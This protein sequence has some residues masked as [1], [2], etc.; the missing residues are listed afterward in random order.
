VKHAIAIGFLTAVVLASTARAEVTLPELAQDANYTRVQLD[1]LAIPRITA[2]LDQLQGLRGLTPRSDALVVMAN[3]QRSALVTELDDVK[4]S[5]RRLLLFFIP[6]TGESFFLQLQLNAG[7]VPEMRFWSNGPSEL[8]IAGDQMQLLE[9]PSRDTFR[10]P[11]I[12]TGTAGQG[13]VS[14][15]ITITDTI[16]CIARSLGIGLDS[17]SLTTRLSSAL[18]SATSTISLALTACNCLSIAGLGSNLVFAT[19]G[20]ITGI[21]K[22]LSC[23]FVTCNASSCPVTTIYLSTPVSSSWSSSC[24]STHR[25]GRYAKF[26]SFLLTATTTV[27]IDLHSSADTYLYLLQGSGTGGSEITEDDDSGPGTDSRI[28][29]TLGPGSYTIEATTYASGVTGSFQLSLGR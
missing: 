21:T 14:E 13:V 9:Q 16:A 4:G 11:H 7:G 10:L 28:V 24:G 27:I 18:C 8:V 5:N 6:E 26:Y 12:T 29:R 3:E 1:H 20:C 17:T 25:S 15:K 23:G 2:V 22:L 19:I